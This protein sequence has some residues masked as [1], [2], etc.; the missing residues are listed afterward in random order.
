MIAKYD[1]DFT[2]IHA[3]EM[4]LLENT[5]KITDLEAQA[6]ADA[7]QDFSEAIENLR[8]ERAKLDTEKY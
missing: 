6:A 1:R 5:Q 2:K 3:T 8:A 7:S 4:A